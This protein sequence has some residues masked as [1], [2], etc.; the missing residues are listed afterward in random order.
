M[1]PKLKRNTRLRKAF[2]AQRSMGD[3][4]DTR[5]IYSWCVAGKNNWILFS[6]ESQKEIK[7]VK[8]DST[9]VKYDQSPSKP[10]ENERPL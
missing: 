8:E 4:E 2:Q 9:D 7:E 3:F 10:N 5:K 1:V 6:N